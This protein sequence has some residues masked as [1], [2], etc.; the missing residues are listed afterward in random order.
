[1]YKVELEEGV[2]LADG[3]GDPPRT[4]VKSN[5]KEFNSLETALAALKRARKFRPFKNAEIQDS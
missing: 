1:M 2:W 3:Q 4:L 5:A